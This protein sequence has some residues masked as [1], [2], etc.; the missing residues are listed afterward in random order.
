MSILCGYAFEFFSDKLNYV[1]YRGEGGVPELGPEAALL[2]APHLSR[3]GSA[4]SG[5]IDRMI[6]ALFKKDELFLFC[7]AVKG[8]V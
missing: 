1:Y 2:R 5:R 8:L 3:G 7:T 6:S 4:D